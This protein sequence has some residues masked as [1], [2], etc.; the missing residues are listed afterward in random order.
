ME[1][2]GLSAQ[3]VQGA[4]TAVPARE[5]TLDVACLFDMAMTPTEAEA[6]VAELYRV[7]KPGGKAI[8]VVPA[9]HNARRWQD[10]LLPWQRWLWPSPPPDPQHRYTGRELVRLYARFTGHKLYKRH[11][12]R[13]DL[14][15]IWRW[16]ALP[17]LER[18]MGR[19]LVLK[20]YKPISAAVAV[21]VA[22]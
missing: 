21:A 14:P 10:R 6:A 1:L 2:R 9:W 18:V 12:R 16:M 22:A 19:Y 15:H 3:Y 11:L 13:S 8:V 20:A 7:L 17:L 5:S 4:A